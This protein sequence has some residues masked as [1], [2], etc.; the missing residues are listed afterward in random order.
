MFSLTGKDEYKYSILEEIDCLLNFDNS[1]NERTKS[2]LEMNGFKVNENHII[3]KFG[4][5]IFR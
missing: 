5:I 2:I 3:T 4:N 1:I